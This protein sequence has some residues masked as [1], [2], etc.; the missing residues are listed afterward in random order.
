M[1]KCLIWRKSQQ[2][3]IIKQSEKYNKNKH[4]W[5]YLNDKRIDSI[6][7]DQNA[8]NKEEEDWNTPTQNRISRKEKFKVKK[9]YKTL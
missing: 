2:F 5:D 6:M 3:N 8:K 7:K 9:I 1:R 4:V